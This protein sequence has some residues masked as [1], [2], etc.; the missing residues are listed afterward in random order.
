MVLDGLLFWA[1]I[2]KHWVSPKKLA[3]K[4][5]CDVRT[6]RRWLGYLVDKGL[7]LKREWD[8]KSR[9]MRWRYAKGQDPLFT[10]TQRTLKDIKSLEDA[11]G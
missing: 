10:R 5:G 6:V 7:K 8:K 2:D 9:E 4:W 1:R 3:A 11:G